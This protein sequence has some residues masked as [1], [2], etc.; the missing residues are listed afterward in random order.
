MPRFKIEAVFPAA[1]AP[2]WEGI[3]SIS[4]YEVEADLIDEAK[5]RLRN[6][7]G[8][9]GLEYKLRVVGVEGEDA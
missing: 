3:K 5:N 4:V 9:H 8:A 1:Q 2:G 6:V 7:L